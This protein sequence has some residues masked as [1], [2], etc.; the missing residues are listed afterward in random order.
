MPRG[1]GKWVP[2]TLL[3]LAVGPWD[4]WNAAN[5]FPADEARAFAREFGGTNPD[6]Q[7]SLRH[8]YWQAVLT[9]VHGAP[10]SVEI[11]DLHEAG[12]EQ[13]IDSAVDCRNNIV[14][15]RIGNLIRS[16]DAW[17]VLSY[18]EHRRLIREHVLDAWRRGDLILSP[19]DPRLGLGR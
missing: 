11:A 16:Q 1:E 5:G 18:D 6:I 15:Q 17:N 7:N 4:A 13:E 10:S 8:A 19:S 3:A 2:P 14:G 12:H 9:S